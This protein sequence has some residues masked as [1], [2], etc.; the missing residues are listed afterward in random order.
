MVGCTPHDQQ[1]VVSAEI[2]RLLREGYAE[3]DCLHF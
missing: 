3:A 1:A 2:I